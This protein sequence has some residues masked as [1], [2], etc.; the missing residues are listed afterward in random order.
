MEIN[1]IW[2]IVGNDLKELKRCSPKTEK[3][4]ED[5]IERDTSIISEKLILIGRQVTTDFGGSIDLLAVDRAGDLVIIEL[6][7]DKTP[8]DVVAQVLDYASW[9]STLSTE[10]IEE[11]AENYHKRALNEVFKEKFGIEIPELNRN[12]KMLIVA[13][14]VDESTERMVKYLS[15]NY[16]VNINIVKFEFFEDDKNNFFLLR[17][18]VLDPEEV[19][20]TSSEGGRKPRRPKINREEFLSACN[21]KERLIFEKIFEI[22]DKMGLKYSW[23]TTGCSIRVPTEEGE[24]IFWYCYSPLASFGPLMSTYFKEIKRRIGEDEVKEIWTKFKESG[25]Y[26]ESG[27][28]EFKIDFREEMSEDKVEKIVKLFEELVMFLKRKRVTTYE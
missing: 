26:L 25:V 14:N 15:E 9:I 4:L 21:E 23:G 5:W 27:E 17:T 22:A 13:I 8:R 16:G 3:E 28:D 18:F 10:R 12:H 1:R 19:E 6:K 7:K 20:R 11:I 24:I 2:K